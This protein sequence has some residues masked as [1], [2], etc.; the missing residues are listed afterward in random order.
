MADAEIALW[1]EAGLRFRG[2]S[3]AGPVTLLD[4][5]SRV[6]AS[7]MQLLLLSLAGCTAA[8]MVV[9]L[10]KMRLP[11]AALEVRVAADRAPEPP[12]RY[13]RVHM[14]Y[15]IGGIGPEQEAQVRQALE[16]SLEKYCS[17]L[18]TLRQ[19]TRITTGLILD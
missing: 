16:L 6:A 18:H 12:R 10:E 5:E 7:P 3:E 1:W 4:G 13:T 9:I 19:D 2:G 8:D 17:V 15:R 11:L 14:E